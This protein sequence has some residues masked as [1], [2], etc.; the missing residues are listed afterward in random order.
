MVTLRRAVP[1]DAPLIMAWR[2]ESSAGRYQPLRAMTTESLRRSL[3]EDANPRDG[4]IQ[5][6][7]YIVEAAPGPVGTI[8]LDIESREH[9][10]G[11]VGYGIGEAFRGR[12]Y[13]TAA[14]RA[15]LAVAF[16]PVGPN[17][18][19][20]EAIAAVENIASRR[21]LERAGFGFEGIARGLLVIGGERVDHA[22]YGILRS[23]W[24]ATSGTEIES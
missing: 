5:R 17:L 3:V 14:L 4:A 7:R 6:A 16:G 9:G 20:V 18:D 2:V 22:R 12:G 15:L 21:A 13:A 23:D 10:Y 8:R 24:L 11:S 19:R 1:D